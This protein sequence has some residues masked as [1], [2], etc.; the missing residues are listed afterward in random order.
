[1]VHNAVENT[2]LT[3][4]EESCGMI[5][6]TG[7]SWQFAM[8]VGVALVVVMLAVLPAGG[9][10]TWAAHPVHCVPRP[11]GAEPPPF[12]VGPTPTAGEGGR[13]GEY[14]PLDLRPAC[15]EGEV[16]EVRPFSPPEGKGN[17]LLG[18]K[19]SGGEA[20]PGAVE[21][22]PYATPKAS[23]SGET[24]RAGSLRAFFQ[25]CDGVPS[26]GSC[27]Y[28]A[29]AQ[30]R[31]EADGGGMI[32]TINRPDQVGGG[33]SLDELAVQ[34]GA[35]DGDIVELGWNVSNGQYGDD[36]PHLF[37]FHWIGWEPTCYDGCEWQQWSGTYFP[38]MDLSAAEGREVYLGYVF[39]EGNWWAWFDN[40]WLGYF[41]G[42][43]WS[44]SYTQSQLLQWFG[45]VASDN[46]IPPQSDMGNGQ[47]PN[48]ERAARM[49]VLCDVD[50]GDWVCWYRD[51]QSLTATVPSYYDIAGTGFGQVDY[52]G[53]GE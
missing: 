19:R 8:R 34:G 10:S 42:S 22:T 5:A 53:R 14:K 52:G 3:H 37:V 28:Y 49:S 21:G 25:A 35:D 26:S 31:R 4:R 45:E 47:F 11:E 1:M 29:A 43:E 7:R 17:P 12:P 23:A 9:S 6:Q 20:T 40:Q 27:Y 33:H 30:Y 24:G 50:A 38:G 15:P 32:A 16:P 51:E 39:W 48:R 46:G 41:P 13:Q 2:P 44:D 36:R 18:A